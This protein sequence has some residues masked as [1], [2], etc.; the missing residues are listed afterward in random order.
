MGGGISALPGELEVLE[1]QQVYSVGAQALPLFI[2]LLLEQML[3]LPASGRTSP[4]T[5]RA[6]CASHLTP[7][8]GRLRGLPARPPSRKP[9]S[10]FPSGASLARAPGLT[11][12]LAKPSK[13]SYTANILCPSEMPTRT[14]ARTAAFMPAAGAP[15]F[16]TPTLQLVCESGREPCGCVRVKGPVSVMAQPA[17]TAA[18][19]ARAHGGARGP[20][21]GTRGRMSRWE[22]AGE[23]QRG[24]GGPWEPRPGQKDT[25]AGAG[26]RRRRSWGEGAGC[27]TGSIPYLWDLGVRQLHGQPLVGVQVALEAPGRKGHVG[28]KGRMWT[29][30]EGL[31][32]G[33]GDT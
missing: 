29:E 21:A 20:G 27:L 28:P 25:Q 32:W 15:T 7:S 12:P 24:R 14:A 8:P 18:H 11:L 19:A 4:P 26:P 33:E 5:G 2:R 31:M 6:R 22:G 3:C 1:E 10:M 23:G 17:S 13:P 30:L 9:E 16:T